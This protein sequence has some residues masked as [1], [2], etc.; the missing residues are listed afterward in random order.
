[1][2]DSSPEKNIHLLQSIMQKI[3]YTYIITN[4]RNGTL[5]VGVTSNLEK[6]MWEHRNKVYK[7]FSSKYE[8]TELVRFQEFPTIQEAITYEK[9]IKWRTRKKK[10]Q[11]IEQMNPEWNNLLQ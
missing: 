2:T 3:W 6:R 9:K 8:L 4:Q 11:L 1:M 7:W 5:Y 10:L